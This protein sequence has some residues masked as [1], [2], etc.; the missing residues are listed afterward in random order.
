MDQEDRYERRVRAL[1]DDAGVQIG[2]DREWDLQVHDER[3]YARA[4][5][6]GSLGLGEAYMDGWWDVGSLDA[7]LLKLM[8]ARL[9][10]RV[11]GAAE[12]ADGIGAWLV[13]RQRGRRS[14]E[15]G[16]HHYDLGNDLYEAMLGKRMVYSCGYWRQATSLDEAQEAKIDLACRKLG[17][18]PGMRLLDIGS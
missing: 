3:L 5:G 16:E 7:F 10:E 4:L 12:I 8:H 17:L 15:V 11:Y 2:G 18:E 14:F 1:L 6:Q 9:D 13:N